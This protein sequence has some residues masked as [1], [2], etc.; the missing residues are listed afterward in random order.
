MFAKY[1]GRQIAPRQCVIAA[2]GRNQISCDRRAW[3]ARSISKKK[4]RP[5]R[6]EGYVEMTDHSA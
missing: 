2:Y 4:N 3:P 6:A 5:G 1:A